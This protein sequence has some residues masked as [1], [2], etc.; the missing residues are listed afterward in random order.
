[1]YVSS[2]P[3][4]YQKQ[5]KDSLMYRYVENHI[6]LILLNITIPPG[7]EATSTTTQNDTNV[8]E[9]EIG[10]MMKITSITEENKGKERSKILL[11]KLVFY[12]SLQRYR[13]KL[14]RE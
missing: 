6:Y 4:D 11:N 5:F 2:D 10:I 12:K 7:S 8:T 1:M 3:E 13:Y 9:T 14:I